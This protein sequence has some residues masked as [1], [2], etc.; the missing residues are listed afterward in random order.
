MSGLD[1]L[2]IGGGFPS[3]FFS[4]WIWLSIY[5]W[6]DYQSDKIACDEAEVDV[7]ILNL[8]LLL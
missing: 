8:V 7:H 2:N 1:S 3:K 6:W 4:V 5:D